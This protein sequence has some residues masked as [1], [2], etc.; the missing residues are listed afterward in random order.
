MK[1]TNKLPLLALLLAVPVLGGARGCVEPPPPGGECICA[2]FYAPVCGADGVTYGNACEADCAEVP[3]AHDGECVDGCLP[4]AC[5]ADCEIGPG[6]DDHGCPTC[7]CVETCFDDAECGPGRRCSFD[8][9]HS[10]CTFDDAACPAVCAGICEDAPP[11][12]AEGEMECPA[13]FGET[14]CVPEASC[15]CPVFDCPP[16]PTCGG[17]AGLECPP[18]MFCDFPDNG[19]GLADGLGYCTLMPDAWIEIYAPVCGCD[20]VTYGNEGEANGHGIDIQ[21]EGVCEEPADCRSTGCPAGERCD[22]CWF[23][24]A[25]LPD[26]A[27]C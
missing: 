27:V 13:C 24:Y 4:V 20:G 23:T 17:F 6:V 14:I 2:D 10:P 19:C 7:E 15:G 16:P 1:H 9:C 18:G 22:L 25:C 26:G 21:H 11:T 12:C 3:I 5:P 8:E